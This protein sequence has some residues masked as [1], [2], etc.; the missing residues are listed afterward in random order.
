MKLRIITLGEPPCILVVAKFLFVKSWRMRRVEQMVRKGDREI[1]RGLQ[2]VN[3][4][5]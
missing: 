5:D 3:L 1:H 2:R 4:E